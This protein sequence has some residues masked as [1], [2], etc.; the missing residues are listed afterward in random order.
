MNLDQISYYIVDITITLCLAALIIGG[1]FVAVISLYN[2]VVL[3]DEYSKK[4]KPIYFYHKLIRET[5]DDLLK[6]KSK[7]D[8][9]IKGL[10]KENAHLLEFYPYNSM[11]ERYKQIEKN[12]VIQTI[13]NYKKFNQF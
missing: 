10:L 13:L 6:N 1:T 12:Y 11:D 9:A 8:Q 4:T 5:Y 7:T 2:Y 3:Q